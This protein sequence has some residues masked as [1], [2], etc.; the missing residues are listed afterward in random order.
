MASVLIA[1]DAAIVRHLLSALLTAAGHR[2]VGEAGS[3]ADTIALYELLRPDVT[4]VDINMPAGD[5]IDTAC[6]IKMLHPTARVILASV[7][8]D[9]TRRERAVAAGVTEF[10]AKP[11]EIGQVNAAIE[12]VLGTKAAA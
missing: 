4:I 3:G 5:G 1:D 7:L 11:F 9:E 10:A 6:A 8:D 12:R 2:V